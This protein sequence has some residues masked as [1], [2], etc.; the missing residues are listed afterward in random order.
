MSIVESIVESCPQEI[1]LEFTR[2]LEVW[3]LVNF[4]ATCRL[5]RGLRL[6]RSL[7]IVVFIRL[8]M[9]SSNTPRVAPVDSSRNSAHIK[10]SR[11]HR[12]RYRS[13]NS[14]WRGHTSWSVLTERTWPSRMIGMEVSDAGTFGA[15]LVL[16]RWRS[17]NS[18]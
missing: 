1:L 8:R 15:R 9:T 2:H 12:N 10:P 16:R 18:R 5:I 7:W 3:D 13:G 11:T 6:E 17:W 14:P 4:L